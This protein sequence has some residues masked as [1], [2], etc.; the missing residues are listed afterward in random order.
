MDKEELTTCLVG[1]VGVIF[2]ATWV[3][4]FDLRK[5]DHVMSVQTSN[6][7]E[8]SQSPWAIHLGKC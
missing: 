5:R 4:Q 2:V 6:V 7:A 1:K 3:F 8:Y